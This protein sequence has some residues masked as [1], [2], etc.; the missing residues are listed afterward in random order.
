MTHAQPTKSSRNTFNPRRKHPQISPP[1]LHSRSQ[2]S[3]SARCSWHT[4]SRPS[5]PASIA[6]IIHN[7][8]S[9]VRP[10]G[11]Y[12]RGISSSPPLL[13]PSSFLRRR[14]GR[15]YK[16]GPD[17][18]KRAITLNRG[19]IVAALAAGKPHSCCSAPRAVTKN[20]S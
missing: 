2:I 5:F 18:P 14:C 4:S 15:V 7:T 1:Q 17:Q 16:V 3:S 12:I 13:V 19:N 20:S 8:H 10:R 11:A 6:R 9:K